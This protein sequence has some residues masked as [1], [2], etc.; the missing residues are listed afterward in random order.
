MSIED[1]IFNQALKGSNFNKGLPPVLSSLLVAQAAHETGNFQSN[2]FKNYNNAF[3][4]SYVP[5]GVYQSGAGTLADNGQPIA[6]Y[7]TIEDS[8]KEV[9]D[10]I[11]RRVKEGKFPADLYTITT[12][13]QYAQLLKAANYYG[14]TLQNY[15]AGLKRFFTAVQSQLEKPPAKA[16]TLI[17]VGLLFYWILKKR[18]RSSL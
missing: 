15:A 4:Y 17:A 14:D 16:F 2:F 3:G 9:V 12:P 11:Y 18:K 13:E 7:K 6:A 10:W 1:R 5:G 8:T